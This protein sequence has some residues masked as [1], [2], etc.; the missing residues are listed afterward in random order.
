MNSP[1]DARPTPNS[2][3]AIP[4]NQQKSG[5]F[6]SQTTLVRQGVVYPV[7]SSG[8]GFIPKSPNQL[9]PAA[10]RHPVPV[11]ARVLVPSHPK[12][13][14]SPSLPL[15]DCNGCKELRDR[16]REDAATVVRDRKVRLSDGDS[17]YAL[18]RSWLR[19]GFPEESQPQYGVGVKSLPRPL[20]P[21]ESYRI[22]KKEAED[23]NEDEKDAEELSTSDLLKRHVKRAKR[24]R[25]RLREERSQRIARYKS[26]LALLLPLQVEQFKSDSVA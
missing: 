8:R 10:V 23:D 9:D 13:C 15:P 21:V 14:F 16:A 18:C 1:A 11:S 24:V 4:T 3:P 2:S 7:A 19:N 26:R 5:Q 22:V 17:L 6:P 20:P 25:S 12:Q